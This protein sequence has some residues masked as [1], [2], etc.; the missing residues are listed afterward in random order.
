[1][2]PLWGLRNLAR[3]PLRT[4]LAVL[5]IT[6]A[7][8]LLLDMVLLAGGLERSFERLVL[9]RGYQIRVTPK[10]TL[11]FDTEATIGPVTPLVAAIRRDPDV[12]A[13][14]PILAVA[15]HARHADSL[16]PLVGYGVDPSGQ[17]I[18]DLLEGSDL[19]AADSAGLLVGRTAAE[20]LGLSVGDSVRLVGRLDPQV[21][22]MGVERRM[23][24][25]GVVRW[26][27]DDRTMRSV[28]ALLP[29]MQRFGWHAGNDRASLLMVRARA[30]SLA[31]GVV[32]RLREAHPEVGVNSVTDLVGQFRERIS[33]FRQ[34]SVILGTISLAVTVLL[35]ATILT[36]TVNERLGEIATLRA[37]G[38]ARRT[39]VTQ[40]LVE[41]AALTL[42][43]GALG[44]LLGL[45]TARYLDTILTAF[46]GLP[47]S[48]SFFVPQPQGL[49]TAA[50]LLLVTGTLAGAWPAWVAARAPIAATLRGEAP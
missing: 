17:G 42:A 14:G 49:L 7:S 10:G 37:L 6:V 46:P 4:V 50:V 21:A 29:V 3:H 11:P 1:M 36:I 5:G 19:G 9:S 28:G 16:L 12:V 35:I 38:V 33:Y 34:V 39:V 44:V 40:V 45:G 43:G 31:G 41:G 24:V 27:Y 30:D 18:Y 8:A 13:A 32:A 47:A 23:V 2:S 26:L 15:L 25:R 48:I 20:A 22:T